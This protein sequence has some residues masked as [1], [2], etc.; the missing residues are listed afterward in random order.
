MSKLYQGVKCTEMSDDDLTDFYRLLY[1]WEDARDEHMKCFGQNDFDQE[2][3]KV[4]AAA[5]VKAKEDLVE[6]VKGLC[7]RKE[8]E[9]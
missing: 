6:L 2:D 3:E 4:K 1:A 9:A 8:V 7:K 5:A